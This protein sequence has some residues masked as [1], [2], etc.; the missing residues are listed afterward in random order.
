MADFSIEPNPTH[1]LT[2]PV[3]DSGHLKLIGVDLEQEMAV[4][5][6]MELAVGRVPS[7][8]HLFLLGRHSSPFFPT[9]HPS[10]IASLCC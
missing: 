10:P 7:L 9:R 8:Q 1:L 4:R 5:D 6:V 3:D 2:I